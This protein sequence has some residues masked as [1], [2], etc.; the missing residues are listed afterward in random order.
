MKILS[1]SFALGILLSC[2]NTA[3]A[4]SESLS[5]VQKEVFKTIEI[6][7]DGMREGDSAKVS[8]VFHKDVSLYSYALDPNGKEEI[9]SMELKT[10]LMSIGSPHDKVWDETIWNPV[11][12]VEGGIAQMWTD[13]AFYVGGEFSHCG[14]DAFHLI[15]LPGSEWQIVHLMDTR[16]REPCDIDQ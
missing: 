13:Y 3:R 16:R 7:F 11:I 6:L 4:Q 10:F 12:R 2:V 8:S 1:S 9:R 15:K 5:P 14:V